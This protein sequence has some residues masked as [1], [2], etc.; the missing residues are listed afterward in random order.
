[1]KTLRT[2]RRKLRNRKK[3]RCATTPSLTR[4]MKT[5]KTRTVRGRGRTKLLHNLERLPSLARKVL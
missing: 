2:S 3:Q 4:R 1:M 5:R